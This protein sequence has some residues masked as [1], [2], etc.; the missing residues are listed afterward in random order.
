M[1]IPIF[2][3]SWHLSLQSN[4]SCTWLTYRGAHVGFRQYFQI[5][6]PALLTIIASPASSGNKV[7]SRGQ[8]HEC[9]QATLNVHLYAGTHIPEVHGMYVWTV[10]RWSVYVLILSFTYCEFFIYLP[11]LQMSFQLYTVKLTFVGGPRKAPTAVP[12]TYGKPQS[13]S[14]CR[15]IALSWWVPRLCRMTLQLRASSWLPRPPRLKGWGL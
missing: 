9:G 12:S 1:L 3:Y 7:T 11:C 4:S 8:N 13:S 5:Y 2:M 14:Q 6:I 10:Q 15:N